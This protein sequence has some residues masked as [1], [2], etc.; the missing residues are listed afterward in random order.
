MHHTHCSVLNAQ[1]RFELGDHK[2]FKRNEID[3]CRSWNQNKRVVRKPSLRESCERDVER[4]LVGGDSD[5]NVS[6]GARRI[7]NG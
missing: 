4:K 3:C 1:C 2:P 6:V 7:R 5:S